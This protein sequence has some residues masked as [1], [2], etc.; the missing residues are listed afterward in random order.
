MTRS[1]SCRVYFVLWCVGGLSLLGAAALAM[2]QERIALVIGNAAY[3][4]EIG[5]LANAGHDAVDMSAALRELGFTVTLVRDAT[6]KRMV[7]AVEEFSRQIRPQTVALFYYSGHGAQTN[8]RNYLIPLGARIETE[9]AVPFQAMAAEE[10][11][12]RMESAGQGESVTLLILDACRNLPFARQT[13]ATSRGLAPMEATRGSLIAFATAPGTEAADGTGRNGTYTKH[14]LRF[15]REPNLLVD[16]MFRHVLLAVEE[17]TDK[18]Q[19]PWVAS[20]LRQDFYFNP[21]AAADAPRTARTTKSPQGA[22]AVI[23]GKD[24]A[25]MLLVP[26]GEFSMGSAED[27]MLHLLDDWPMAKRESLEREVPRHRV[28]LDAFY[29]DKYEVTKARFQQFVQATNHRTQ[30]ERDGWGWVYTGQKDEQMTGASWRTP[31][32]P[33]QESAGQEQHPV[34]QV[35]WEDAKAYCT[36]AG[37][38]LPTEAEWEK[39][40]RGAEG[41]IYPWGNQ[42]DGTLL[43]ACDTHCEYE[44]KDDAVD[45]GYR[46]TAPVGSYEGGKSPYGVYDMAGNVWEWVADWFDKDYYKHSPARNPRGP[47]AGDQAV[48][49]G[50]G[51]YGNALRVRASFR[52]KFAPETRHDNIGFRCAKSS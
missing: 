22:P 46:Y 40:A 48:L 45:D 3:G 29:I 28:Y 44:G 38:R 27:E 21:V 14:L 13:R 10:V 5:P 17:E 24:G 33:G 47:N 20:S 30:A 42:F 37:K 8:G 12:A 4:R 50:G 15:M 2:A 32:G 51:W 7:D 16:R 35:S 41:R 9:A 25:E 26:A 39:A 31:R 6:H 49:R 36:W 23:T 19:I 34:V 1:V 18:R 52:S 11:L 43:N